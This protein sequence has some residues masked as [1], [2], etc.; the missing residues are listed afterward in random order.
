MDKSVKPSSGRVP[1]P[2]EDNGDWTTMDLETLKAYN[3]K[4]KPLPT[5]EQSAREFGLECNRILDDAMLKNLARLPRRVVWKLARTRQR[6][7][8][9]MV[10]S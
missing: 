6:P 5:F 3:A 10:R 9:R 4:Q 1:N 8:P 7:G 2:P